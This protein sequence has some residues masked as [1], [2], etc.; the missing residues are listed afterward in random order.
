MLLC[1]AVLCC[2]EELCGCVAVWKF[3]WAEHEVLK[4]PPVTKWLGRPSF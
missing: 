1:C 3:L 2:W 4:N